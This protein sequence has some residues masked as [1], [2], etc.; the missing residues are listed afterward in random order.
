MKDSAVELQ[1]FKKEMKT[2]EV[3]HLGVA[4]P[5]VIREGKPLSLATNFSKESATMTFESTIKK[6]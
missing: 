4:T 5:Q 3:S 1:R 6:Q 2:I